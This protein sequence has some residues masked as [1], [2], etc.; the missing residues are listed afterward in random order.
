MSSSQ[1]RR[2]R[3]REKHRQANPA[4]P[5]PLFVRSFCNTFLIKIAC[6]TRLSA[7]PPG[8]EFCCSKIALPLMNVNTDRQIDRQT[9]RPTEIVVTVM[10]LVIQIE[11]KGGRPRA[12]CPEDEYND[13]CFWTEIVVIVVILIIQL[14]YKNNTNIVATGADFHPRGGRE[15]FRKLRGEFEIKKPRK[16][17]YEQH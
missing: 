11:Y 13:C 3:Q 16:R 2:Q 4:N 6:L 14:Q 1:R 17:N 10:T 7:Y 5:L 15:L 9:D 8:A 12:R